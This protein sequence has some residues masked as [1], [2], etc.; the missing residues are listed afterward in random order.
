MRITPRYSIMATQVWIQD[1]YGPNEFREGR[2]LVDSAALGDGVSAK[3]RVYTRGLSGE[4]LTVYQ[5]QN[6][7][8][9]LEDAYLQAGI[10]VAVGATGSTNV[11]GIP[12]T[13]GRSVTAQRYDQ[14]RVWS[15][16]S[17]LPRQTISTLRNNE[18]EWP[19]VATDM[20]AP[21]WGDK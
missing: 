14:R 20:R 15:R 4:W 11:Q 7:L 21:Y 16:M 1:R 3:W 17:R 5:T 12:N 9:V 18:I 10:P 2:K 13:I 8:G 6:D 19:M